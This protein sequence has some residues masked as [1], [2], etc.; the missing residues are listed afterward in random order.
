ML[1]GEQI[2]EARNRLGWNQDTLGDKIHMSR[3]MIS[4]WETD[5]K[6]VPAECI[7]KLEEVLQCKFETEQ[8]Q[9]ELPEEQAAE[10]IAQD[11]STVA[12]E[13]KIRIP[14]IF[15]KSVPAWQCAAIAG[16]IFI[17]MLIIMLCITANLQKQIDALNKQPATPYSLAWYQQIDE[18]EAGKAYVTIATDQNPVKGGKRQI[19]HRNR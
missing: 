10:T 16:G 15:N 11:E 9:A 12:A 13:K 2:K 5:R 4:H 19:I 14:A 6:P 18:Q 17:V 1:I 3:Q 7:S 8:E